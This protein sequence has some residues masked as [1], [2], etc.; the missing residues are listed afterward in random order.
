MSG[1]PT[2][3]GTIHVSVL[4]RT[5]IGLAAACA[6]LLTGAAAAEPPRDKPGDES[7]GIQAITPSAAPGLAAAIA[8]DPDVVTGAAFQTTTGGS[9]NA[10][11]DSGT[12]LGGFPTDGSTYAIMT[13]GNAT[14]AGNDQSFFASTSNGGGAVRG[15]AERDVTVLG[16]NL[17]VPV[18]A[19]CLTIDFRFLSEEYPNFVGGSVSDAF[20]AELDVTS[21]TASGSAVS[22]PNNF[23]F[24]AEGNV[25]SV[26]TAT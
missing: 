10:V 8:A 9:P 25:I 21:W 3:G 22:A 11:A 1:A 24:D 15:G 13:S 16:I 4:R 2:G 19:N 20:V 6:L 12:P 17:A 23:A 5:V 14:Q 18:A 26:N 7:P